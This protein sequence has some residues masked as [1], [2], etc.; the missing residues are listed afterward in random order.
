MN[1]TK[2]SDDQTPHVVDAQAVEETNQNVSSDV[3]VL[4]N[5]ESLI[6]SHILRLEERRDELKKYKE[7]MESGFTHDPS[8]QEAQAA[9]K[10]ANKRKRD[11][12]AQL[13]KLPEVRSVYEKVMECTTDIK[14]MDAA[15]SDYLREYQRLSGSNEIVDDN[16]Q[17]HEITYIAKLMKKAK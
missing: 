12:K 16:G 3:S 1:M 9:V 14:E 11:A 7:L 15:L 13:L 17:V 10:E 8:Y 6:K 2:L 4:L 5:L